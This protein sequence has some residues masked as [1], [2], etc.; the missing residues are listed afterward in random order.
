MDNNIPQTTRNVKSAEPDNAGIFHENFSPYRGRHIYRK[1]EP[2]GLFGDRLSPWL[3]SEHPLTDAK[4]TGA[5]LGRAVIGYFLAVFPRSFCV[6]IDDHAGKGAGYLLSVYETVCRKLNARPSLLCKTPRGL[7]AFYFLTHPVPE[8]LLTERA[9]AAVAGVPA[10][11]KPT[12]QAGTRIPV[13]QR[14]IDPLTWEPLGRP[15]A[16]AV[17]A[18]AKYHPVELFG[19][20]V[21]PDA[22]VETLK[23][24]KDRV[25]RVKIW[26]KIG[27]LEAEYAGGIRA[28]TT[29]DVLCE[30]IPVYRS[31][32]L[33][34]EEAAA[35][36]S[37]LLDPSYTG[38][39]R[40]YR[41][42]VRRV[43]SFYKKEPET[44]FR[45]MPAQDPGLFTEAIAGTIAELVTGPAESRQ[46]K[47][48]LTQRKRTVKKA[49]LL[50]E[51]WKSY[52]ESVVRDRRFLEMW[53]YL[54]P[55]FKKN[56][57]E[58]YFPL[59]SNILLKIHGHYEWD[60]L[61]FLLEIGYLERAPYH[62]TSI[63]GVCY[64]Y[65]IHSFKFVGEKPQ[66]PAPVKKIRHAKA[67]SRAEQV[68]EFKR[69]HQ[70]ATVREI[71]SAF[72]CSLDTVSRALKK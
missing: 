15:F 7:H 30:L 41:R 2:A 59:S 11:V 21:M 24:R 43:Q 63:Y 29:N 14:L 35:E 4:I 37:A 48:A 10:E 70:N 72:G 58:G 19:L 55:Y 65:K 42:L 60:V 9:R 56:T 54:Y 69:Q 52:I 28:G 39:L 3:T 53:N 50:V 25:V 46:Q 57:R 44:R 38:E 36:F 12:S 17:G 67:K 31:G 6:D 18:A 26:E 71:A 40:A 32:G 16:A 34:P 64:Y 61:P 68:R 66:K 27:R 22:V 13:E 1:Q 51:G 20:S 5:I 47:A 33:T 49:V 8:L 23:S 45:A 62:Y